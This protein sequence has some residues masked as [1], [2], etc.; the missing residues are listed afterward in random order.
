MPSHSLSPPP[1]GCRSPAEVADPYT[2]IG[3]NDHFSPC[4]CSQSIFS[5]SRISPMALRMSP[6]NLQSKSVSEWVIKDL[7]TLHIEMV[8]LSVNQFFGCEAQDLPDPRFTYPY[9]EE[10]L[11]TNWLFGYDPCPNNLTFSF[12]SRLSP[13]ARQ[14]L[15]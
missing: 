10:M 15:P 5:G 11:K 8:P 1:N 12:S 9:L 13:K 3:P 6:S 14:K 2:F 7:D 4:A